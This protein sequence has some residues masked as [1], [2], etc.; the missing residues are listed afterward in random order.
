MNAAEPAVE[1]VKYHVLAGL[2]TVH[3]DCPLQ[4]W[5]RFL[6]QMQDTLNM[7]RT[8]RRNAKLLACEEVESPFDFN[9]TPMSILGTKGLAYLNPD[10]RSTWQPHGVDTFY[11][12][13]KPMHYRLLEMFDLNTRRYQASGKYKLYPTHCK[14][15]TISEADRTIIAATELLDTIC[16]QK[17]PP[18]RRQNANISAS[19]I[20]SPRY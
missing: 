15:P 14:V 4:L 1:S 10:N 5:D 6:A 2:A 11:T 9:K 7:L 20:N 17:Y 13:G 19:S 12:G 18:K 16:T 3:P 8:S